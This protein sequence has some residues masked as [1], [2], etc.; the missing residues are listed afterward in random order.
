MSES[1]W[2]VALVGYAYKTR[3]D[4]WGVKDASVLKS[5]QLIQET[6]KQMRLY[7]KGTV[8]EG[9][10]FEEKSGDP[11]N[12]YVYSDSSFAPESDE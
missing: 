2:G 10:K 7:L 12:L 1:H 5:T 8:D 4:V 3:P 6:A 11:I 9:L